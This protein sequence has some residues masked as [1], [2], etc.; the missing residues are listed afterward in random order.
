[1]NTPKINNKIV[2]IDH[3]QNPPLWQPMPNLLFASPA[4]AGRTVC[5]W[6]PFRV[7][8]TEK[9]IPAQL[10]QYDAKTHGK[11]LHT[12]AVPNVTVVLAIRTNIRYQIKLTTKFQ[13]V[14]YRQQDAILNH[15]RRR[16]GC[17]CDRRHGL[18]SECAEQR[19]CKL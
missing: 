19:Q 2:L 15:Y 10:F 7:T 11:Q 6:L 8:L 17:A 4:S 5:H 1:M 12:S 3:K 16:H 18:K 9:V 13:N 14:Q